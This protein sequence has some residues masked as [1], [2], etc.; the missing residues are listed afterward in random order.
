M[1][2][3][4]DELEPNPSSSEITIKIKSAYAKECG[5]RVFKDSMIINEVHEVNSKS[6]NAELGNDK[7]QKIINYYEKSIGS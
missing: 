6:S 3:L 7:L 5:D 2:P 1:S 4:S